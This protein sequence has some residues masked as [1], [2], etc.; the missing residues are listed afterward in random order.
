M[1]AHALQIV[2]AEFAARQYALAK[3]ELARSFL[4]FGYAREW[5][6]RLPGAVDVDS[7]TVM[8]LLGASPSSSGLALVGAAAFGDVAFL[9]SLRTSLN[10]AGFPT[11][12]MAGLRYSAGYQ[13]GDAVL[14]YA[15]A[16]GPLWAEVERRGKR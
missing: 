1:A 3:R 14:L 5:P 12:S 6:E 7:S 13:L 15:L 8:P 9:D 16:S 10:C 11:H 2:D 4:G